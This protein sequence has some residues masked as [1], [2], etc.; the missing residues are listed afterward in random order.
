MMR[1]DLRLEGLLPLQH[2]DETYDLS[3]RF[4]VQAARVERVDETTHAV[5]L[6]PGTIGDLILLAPAR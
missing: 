5:K 4:Q 2:H 6:A 3:L 1:R